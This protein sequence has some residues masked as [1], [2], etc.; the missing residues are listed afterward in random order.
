MPERTEIPEEGIC[1]PDFFLEVPGM[2]LAEQLTLIE[3]TLY[4]QI[5][6]KIWVGVGLCGFFFLGVWWLSKFEFLA[7]RTA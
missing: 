6:V 5:E 1:L 3:Y 7:A 2:M 4:K